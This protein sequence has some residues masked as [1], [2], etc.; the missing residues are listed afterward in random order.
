M[1]ADVVAPEGPTCRPPRVAPLP[2]GKRLGLLAAAGVPILIINFAAPY[3]GL[4]GL[5]ITF[6]R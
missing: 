6:F 4:I 2:T 1:S 5:P 3:L